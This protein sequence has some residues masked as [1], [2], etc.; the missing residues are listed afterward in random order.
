[1]H[2]SDGSEAILAAAREVL[3]G[4]LAVSPRARQ[5][6]LERHVGAGDA[7]PLEFLSDRELEVFELLG[8]GW[9]PGQIARTLGVG[10]RT[11][12]THRENARLKLGLSGAAELTP[13][14]MRHMLRSG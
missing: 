1:M 9:S 7:G 6:L 5:R 13:L 2:K 4:G 14:A 11:V 10:E 12:A 3:R 8:D